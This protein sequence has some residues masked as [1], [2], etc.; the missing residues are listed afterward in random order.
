MI[1]NISYR[2]FVHGTENEDKIKDAL[3]TLFPNIS[4]ER[5]ETE[6]YYKNPVI[7][8]KEKIDKKREIKEF[9]QRLQNINEKEKESIFHDLERKMDDNGNL[10]L[11]F[12]KQEAYHGNWKIVEHGDSIHV[13]IKIAAYP[14]KKKVAIKIAQDILG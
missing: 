13:R 5:E 6:G 4:F 12:N 7:I 10:F 11:R 1:H 14:A 8:L 9:I 2:V 3:I